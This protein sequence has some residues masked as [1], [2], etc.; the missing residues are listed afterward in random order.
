[1]I[2][3]ICMSHAMSDVLIFALTLARVFDITFMSSTLAATLNSNSYTLIHC[4]AN[5]N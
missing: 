3:Q 4:I 1:M 2:I 5:A